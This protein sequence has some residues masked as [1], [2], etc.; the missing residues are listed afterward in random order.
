MAANARGL[1]DLVSRIKIDS[2]GVDKALGDLATQFGKMKGSMALWGVAAAVGFGLVAEGAKLAI[3][4][5]THLGEQVENY[6]RVTGS[7]AEESGR[8]VQTFEALGVSEE[9]ASKSMFKLSKAIDQHSGK[10]TALGIEIAHEANGNV[11]LSETLFNVA[12]AYNATA[13]QQVKNTIVFTAFGRAGRDMIPILEQGSAALREMEGAARLTFTEDDL[14][15]LKETKIHQAEVK[16]GWDAMWESLGQKLIPAQD[17]LAMAFLRGEYESKRLHEEIKAGTITYEQYSGVSGQLTEK[18]RRLRDEWDK[19]FDS[20]QKLKHVIN[21]QAAATRDAAEAN[22]RL[23]TSTDKLITE[24][25]AAVNAGFALKLANLAVSES[26]LRVDQAQE[27]TVTASDNTRKAYDALQLAIRTF[28]K[29]SEQAKFAADALTKAQQ[30]EQL[31]VD[32]VTR[33]QIAQEDS[34]YRAAA[35]ARK[36][37]Q[38]TDIATTGQKDATK[39]TQA[40][41]NKL[42][43]ETNALAPASPLRVNLQAYIDKLRDEIPRDIYTNL[44]IVHR[45]EIVAQSSEHRAAGGPVAAGG[46]YT[47][48]ERGPETLVMGGSG[49]YVIPHGQGGGG[50]MVFAP[51]Y[52]ITGVGADLTANMK[53]INEQSF[54]D[55]R[56][57]LRNGQLEIP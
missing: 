13:D 14:R 6:K 25:E 22:D 23:W 41:I 21:E 32:E 5:Y 44:H 50:G 55:L 33:A 10:L 35:A 30:D 12:N 17:A 29:S 37:Q 27:R 56:A 51:T 2:S 45:D 34:Y 1:P 31:A 15:R 40:Y 57:M 54:R 3:D 47:V 8:M 9:S 16:Q 11:N 19:Q 24:E 48:G 36:L 43:E 7:S 49:G 20:S 53:T 38:D 4:K 52:N 42:Q 28:G 18:G 39:E 26:Q 46:I